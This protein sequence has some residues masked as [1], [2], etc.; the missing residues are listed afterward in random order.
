[1]YI[2]AL[3]QYLLWPAF[4]IAAWFIIKASLSY[5]EK[6]FPSG[7]QPAE[8]AEGKSPETNEASK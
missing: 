1:M 4:I 5:Y 3:I 8:T 7:N 6:K 2:P